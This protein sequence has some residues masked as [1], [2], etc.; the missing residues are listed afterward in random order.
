MR[1]WLLVATC[2]GCIAAAA[3]ATVQYPGWSSTA[4]SSSTARQMGR[5]PNTLAPTATVATLRM[6]S[7]RRTP[8]CSATSLCCT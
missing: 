5:K 3:G 7:R 6:L 8:A 2:A 1:R 4:A